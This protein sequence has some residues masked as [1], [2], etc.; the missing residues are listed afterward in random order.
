ME[1]REELAEVRGQLAAVEAEMR[2]VIVGQ[3]HAVRS[4]ITA[5]FCGG[6]VL[7]EGLPG[8]GKTLMV[9]T[10][11]DVLHLSYARIQFTPDLMP[12]DITGTNLVEFREGGEKGFRFEPGPVFA[13]LLLADEINRA[14]P[15]TQ[16]A[17]L[18][19]M[20]EHEVTVFGRHF[21]IEEPFCTVAT[22]NP[23]EMEGTYPLPE[24]QLDRFLFKVVI[25]APPLEDLKRI[26]TL[27]GAE[28]LPQPR[29][30]LDREGL[31]RARSLIAR[32][33][34]AEPVLDFA[35][36]LVQ[37]T[38]PESEGAPARTRALVRFGASPRG[39]QGLLAAARVA[40]ARDGRFSVAREDVLEHLLPVLRHRVI[41]GYE[42]E[43]QRVAVDELLRDLAAKLGS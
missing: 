10:L 21:P 19:A 6:H 32:I 33:P 29:K 16:S 28:A 7:L 31:L 17:L 4:L 27:H 12:A 9:R 5:V 20:Q 15:K 30:V 36:R 14:S 11:R 1:L 40:C 2:L 13:N 18:Q 3:E 39:L 25:A 42:G 43:V 35:A 38:H 34:V 41:L 22:Q 8:L 37:A 26:A 24:A 23:I